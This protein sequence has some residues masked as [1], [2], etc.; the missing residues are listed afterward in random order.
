MWDLSGKTALVTG[1]SRG[2]GKAIVLELARMGANVAYCYKKDAKAAKAVAD[3]VEEENGRRPFYIQAL[4]YPGRHNR[5][6]GQDA[7]DERGPGPAWGASCPG[8]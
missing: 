6:K 5:R 7:I 3:Q 8:E 4:L 2:L 1:G